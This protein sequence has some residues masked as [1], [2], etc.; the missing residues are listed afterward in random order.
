MLETLRVIAHSS[1]LLKHN[2][3]FLFNGA[4]ENLLQVCHVTHRYKLYNLYAK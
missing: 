2:V 3:I 1:K 4:E